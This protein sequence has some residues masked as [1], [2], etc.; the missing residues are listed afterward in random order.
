MRSANAPAM[1]A[2]VMIANIPWY[3]MNSR[4]GTVAAGVLGLH[5]DAVHE[6][7]VE[8]ADEPAVR[9]A[10]RERVADDRPLHA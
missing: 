3:I 4:C 6:R 7:V 10:E 1:S 8:A 2:G 9:L 5:A